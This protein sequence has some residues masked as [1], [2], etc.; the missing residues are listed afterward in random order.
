[1]SLQDTINR[2]AEQRVPPRPL[3]G[4]ASVLTLD[5]ERLPGQ[6]TVKHRGLTVTGDFW[7]LGAW[8][9]TIGRRIHPDDVTEWPRTVLVCWKWYGERTVHVASEWDDGP[10]D[11]LLRVWEAY[12]RADLL[13]GHNVQAFDTKHLN[14][15]WRDLGLPPPTPFK[16]LDTY[17][18]AR[19]TFGDESKT[20]AALT[21]RLGIVTKTDRYSVQVA[22]DAVAGVKSQQ[23]R[24]TRYC[25]GDVRA[26][27]AFVDRLRGWLPTHPHTLIGGVD[28]TDAPTCNQCWGDNLEP[29]GVRLAQVQTF[30]LYRCMDCGANV[31]ATRYAARTA[32]TRGVR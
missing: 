29:N 13:Y 21:Q 25:Q 30:P 6:A 12:D 8:K 7:D 15:G 5:L 4:A 28:E 11:M 23:R 22:R 1:M 16:T 26:S 31:T 10:E 18:E 32:N 2:V 24:I 14:T 9:H 3:Q 27:E 17:S 20:L 19:R